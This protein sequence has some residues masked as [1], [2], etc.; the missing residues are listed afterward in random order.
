MKESYMGYRVGDRLRMVHCADP[1]GPILP[2]T[3]GT[4]DYIDDMNTLHMAWDNGKTLGVCLEE[5]VVEKIP[6]ERE[7]RGFERATAPECA[8]EV[9]FDAH[10]EKALRAVG[11]MDAHVSE[12]GGAWVVRSA[13]LD[14][15]RRGRLPEYR[16]V[17]AGELG[18]LLDGADAK[19][20]VDVG[21]HDEGGRRSFVMIA[22]G[23]EY[24]SPS[25]AG[26]AK[27]AFECRALTAKVAGDFRERLDAGWSDRGDAPRSMFLS[28]RDQQSLAQPIEDCRQMF[29]GHG[30]RESRAPER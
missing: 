8:D 20:G 7:Y 25:G 16:F 29:A 5:D 6:F 23:A 14:A 12:S 10:R 30:A 1:Y 26:L 4:I 13:C 9:A 19:N 18:A 11:H 22:Y 27:E 2:G 21:F 17:E 28:P 15:A 24:D 3:K